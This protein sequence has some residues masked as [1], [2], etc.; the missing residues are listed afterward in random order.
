[1]TSTTEI[2]ANDVMP[3]N[4]THFSLLEK[5]LIYSMNTGYELIQTG[6]GVFGFANALY[7]T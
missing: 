3:K 2:I 1:M 4:I 7:E 5:I 6:Y